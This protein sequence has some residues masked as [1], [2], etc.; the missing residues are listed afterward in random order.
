MCALNFF[1]VR[2]C[3]REANRL[4]AC[5]VFIILFLAGFQVLAQNSYPSIDENHLIEARWRYTYTS[6]A[7]SKAIIHKAGQDYA[8]F[9]YFK[10]DNAFDQYL[11]G[12]RNS[13][14]WK[15]NE[16]KNKI[17]Y[18]FR[19]NEWWFVPEITSKTMVL[20]YKVGNGHYRYHFVRVNPDQSPFVRGPFDLPEVDVLGFVESKKSNKRV[21][22]QR[23]KV[24]RGLFS[25]L[26]RKKKDQKFIEISVVGGGFYGGIDPVLKDYTVIKT[27]G[28][29]LHEFET[30]GKGLVKNKG[31]ISREKLVELADFIEAKDFFSM[32]K[33][34]GCTTRL[35]N[36]RKRMKPVPI[37]LRLTVTYGDRTKMVI[38]AIHGRDNQNVQYVDYP[39]EID[40]II[41]SIQKYSSDS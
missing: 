15:L 36:K 26:R 5:Y 27:N 39:K 33:F 11:N 29:I 10:F 32:N 12:S 23:K 28:R 9:L 3:F 41:R 14:A 34:Y 38:V 8:Y 17:Y 2:E 13:G 4:R 25:F 24:R 6:H 37:P 40:L 16:E 22:R 30:V 20:E 35:C 19:K 1:E 7:E 18:P 31:N 21:T